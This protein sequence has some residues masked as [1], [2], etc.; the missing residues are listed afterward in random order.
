MKLE[1]HDDQ[2]EVLEFVLSHPYSIIALDMGMG[3]TPISLG[4]KDR[5]PEER[6][7]VV[8]PASIIFNWK[9]EIEKWLE[10]QTVT[11]FKANKDVYYPVDS[12]FVILSYDMAIKHPYLFEWA[13]TVILD[14]ATQI[15][16]MK[17]Q[18]TQKI[19]QHIYENSVP[20]VH[21][22]TGTPILNRV[23]EFYSLIALCNYNPKTGGGQFL[24]KFTND[25]DFADRY[26][27]RVEFEKW[28]YDKKWGKERRIRIVRWEGSKN[29]EELKT[30]LRG[31]YIR[32]TSK[33]PPIIYQ[34]IFVED[35]NDEALLAEFKKFTEE[36]TS[37]DSPIKRDAA[38]KKA[39]LTIRYIET[40]LKDWETP[41]LV[42]TDHREPCKL[43]A[44][45]FGSD[46]ITGEMSPQKRQEMANRFQEGQIPVLAA[47][48]GSM[49]MGHTLTASNLIVENDYPWVP[50]ILKQTDFRINRE[51]QKRQCYVH[52]ILGSEQDKYILNAV[53]QKQ[54]VIDKIY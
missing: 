49:S 13:T 31:I 37:V 21:L 39:P 8:C 2:K 5:L 16:E 22:L 10:N 6:F 46:P 42:F 40:I 1:L 9:K 18:R 33:R 17:T 48:Y 34:D 14:E 36:N 26:S 52:R 43:I 44:N 51:T 53:L 32:K 3:K 15:K 30:W 54:N 29:V 45:H 19:H 38:L 12:D 25:I 27:H 41:I 11:T 35:F 50:G 28:M 20:R 23:K 4:I 7:L 47:T 24:K